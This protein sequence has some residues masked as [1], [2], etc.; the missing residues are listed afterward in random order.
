M[1]ITNMIN[2]NIFREY[3]V[4]GVYPTELDE[5]VSYTFGKA[6]GT[7]IKRFHQ[8]KCIVG[9]DNRLSSDS[10]TDALIKGI[11]STGIDVI[12]LGWLYEMIV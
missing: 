12:N 1:K 11:L 10:L 8:T 3:D 6:Y 9:H 7:Y 2:P 5:D 4:R